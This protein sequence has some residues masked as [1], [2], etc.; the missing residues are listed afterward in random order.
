MGKMSE[1]VTT[2][3]SRLDSWKSALTGLGGS[4]DK[5]T[6]YRFTADEL[7]NP[8]VCE[9]LYN[10]SDLAAKICDIFPDDALAEGVRYAVQTEDIALST[11]YEGELKDE[12][13][14]LNVEQH[15]ANAGAWSRAHGDCFVFLAVDDG[16]GSLAEPLVPDRVRAIQYLKVVERPLLSVLQHYQDPALPSYGLPEVYAVTG[17]G[18]ASPT[19]LVHETRFLKFAG[20]RT[21]SRQWQQLGYWHFSV[22]QRVALVLRDFNVTWDSASILVQNA[23]QGIYKVAGLLEIIASKDGRTKLE[24]RMALID[25][26]R[27]AARSLIVDAETEGFDFANASFTGVPDLLDRFSSRLAAATGIPVTLLMGEAPGGLQ[28]TGDSDHRGWHKRVRAYQ[29]SSLLPQ[30]RALLQLMEI[31][32][33]IPPEAQCSV[34]FAP[35]EQPTDAEQ[36]ALR[37]TVAETDAIYIASEVLQPEEIAL[38]RFGAKGWSAETSIDLAVRQQIVDANNESETKPSGDSGTVSARVTALLALTD[39]VAQGRLPL[40]AAKQALMNLF[41]LTAAQ[42]DEQLA[43]VHAVDPI[44]SPSAPVTAAKQSATPAEGAEPRGVPS[45]SPGVDGAAQASDTQRPT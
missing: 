14:R 13:E 40:A 27:S 28:S 41:G 39:A 2:V 31:A 17:T 35:I 33:K 21:S 10:Y 15:F 36:A 4:R 45:G 43:G 20:T 44:A 32:L 1:I 42:A 24:E 7:L 9:D 38:A 26:S 30:L 16:A 22:L 34:S 25:M 11:R 3:G 8:Q 29:K 37:K 19:V 23:S 12:S 6:S 18:Q 5:R